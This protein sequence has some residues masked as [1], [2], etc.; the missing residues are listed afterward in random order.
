MLTQNFRRVPPACPLIVRWHHGFVDTV[1]LAAAPVGFLGH[2]DAL[3]DKGIVGV[4]NMCGEYRG[5][6]EDYRRLGIEQLWLPTVVRL[7]VLEHLFVVAFDCCSV[8]AE[9]NSSRTRGTQ[10]VGEAS[11]VERGDFRPPLLHKST[12]CRSNLLQPPANI[13]T[14]VD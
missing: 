8:P 4:I 1:Y 2:A 13:Q 11:S 10:N 9:K 7:R 12:Y 14:L 6:V 5:P 3:H